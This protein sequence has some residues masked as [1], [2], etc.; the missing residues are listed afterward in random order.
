MSKEVKRIIAVV[1]F[2]EFLICLGMSLI[3]PVM[4]F[5][6]NEYHF[7]AFDMGVMSSL[8]AFVQF[9]ASPIVGRISDKTGRKPMLVWGLLV[10]SIAEFVFALSQRLWL[11]DLSRAVDGLSAAMFV[12]TSMALAADLTSVKDRAKV[13]GWLSAAFSGGLIL[14]PGLGGILA[15]ISYKFPFWV[16]GILGIISTVVAVILLPKDSDERFK[17]ST[18]NP[19]DAL[20]EG[21]WAQVKSLLTPVMTMLFLMIFIMAFGL[22]GF[23]SIYSL[24]VN[25]VH[26]FDLQSIALVLTLNGI[27][28]LILQVFLFDRMVQWWGEVRV[29]RYCFFASAIGTAFVIY[30]H[31]HWQLIVATLVVFEAFDMLRPAITT[32]LTKMSKNNQGLL[33]GVN[34]SLTSVG[35]IIGPLISGAL[36][37]I[38]YQY[39]YWIVIVFLAISFII[40]VGLEHL[41]RVNA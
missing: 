23:E 18:K 6:K 5:I 13:I 21:G 28:S 1:I 25:E 39:P 33:N 22:A 19:E 7:S 14:G 26:H 20:L 40:T 29:I 2:C 11:F 4:P 15:N 27:I 10:F 34:M 3:F 30:D 32:L 17:S 37:D 8:F 35:N 12:P 31:S 9:I 24:Y 36:L 41:N 16:A 38:N